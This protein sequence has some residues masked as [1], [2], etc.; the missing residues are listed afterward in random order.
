MN[1]RKI[2]TA[3]DLFLVKLAT[4]L[5]FVPDNNFTF[6]VQTFPKMHHFVSCNACEAMRKASEHHDNKQ[7][8]RKSGK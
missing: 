3:G 2:M 7:Q 4:V 8:A 1:D 6:I 5:P